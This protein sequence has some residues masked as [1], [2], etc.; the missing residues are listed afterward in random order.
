MAKEYALRKIEDNM[1][2]II[3][4]KTKEV[5]FKDGKGLGAL[6]HGEKKILFKKEVVYV[7][8]GE[9]KSAFLIFVLLDTARK[10]NLII[11]DVLLFL[12][13]EELGLFNKQINVSGNAYRLGNYLELGWICEDYLHNEKK[14]HKLSK[15][16]NEVVAFFYKRL[17]DNTDLVSKNRS[18]E[19][20]LDNRVD[21][22]LDDYFR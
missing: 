2:F 20:N 8:G 22:A 17:D 15:K 3:T 1:S 7:D 16:G 12:Y 11:E 19:T 13:L 18:T 9:N 4:S 21:S 6:K 5:D 10:F 14:L